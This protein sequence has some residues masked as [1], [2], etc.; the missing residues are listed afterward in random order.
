M[1]AV[2]TDKGS[3]PGKRGLI[4]AFI[5]G[6]VLVIASIWSLSRALNN[7]SPHG[8]VALT[9]EAATT[10]AVLS[11]EEIDRRQYELAIPA[12][13]AA[14]SAVIQTKQNNAEVKLQRAKAKVN[15]LIVE[16]MKQYVRDNP[17]LDTRNIE[18]QIKK[19][20]NQGA[21]IQ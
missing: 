2:Q 11:Q 21:K 9:N 18:E 16:R 6:A 7:S 1:G 15:Q 13:V 8:S 4:A 14:Q 19:R 3:A 12:P 5:F 17:Y 20:E 10:D